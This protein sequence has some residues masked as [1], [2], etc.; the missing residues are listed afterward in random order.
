MGEKEELDNHM[1]CDKDNQPNE[2]KISN[3]L[4]VTNNEFFKCTY[5]QR[6]IVGYPASIQHQYISGTLKEQNS[7]QTF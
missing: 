7:N 4:H 5:T 3:L 1:N 2:I 6:R